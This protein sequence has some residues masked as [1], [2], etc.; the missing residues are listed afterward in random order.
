MFKSLAIIAICILVLDFIWLRFIF[1]KHFI[2]MLENIQGTS[3]VTK[4]I[5]VFIAYVLLVAVAYLAITKSSNWFE[6]FL[7]GFLI[8]GIY[9]ATNYATLTNYN[10]GIA[11]VDTLWGGVLFALTFFIHKNVTV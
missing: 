4:P 7:F 6:A 10:L 8:Y 11:T 3:L 5:G 9:D 2:G 1:G